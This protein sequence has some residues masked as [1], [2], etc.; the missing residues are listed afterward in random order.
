MQ[1]DALLPL[2]LTMATGNLLNLEKTYEM[3]LIKGKLLL[4]TKLLIVLTEN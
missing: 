4:K 2:P 3:S 1:K